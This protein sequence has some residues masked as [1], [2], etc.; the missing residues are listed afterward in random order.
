MKW[1]D[2]IGYNYR[3]TDLQAALGVAQMEKV[4]EIIRK[5]QRAAAQYNALLKESEEIETPFV[6]QGY[7]HAYQSYV[8]WYKK[9]PISPENEK[10]IDGHEIDRANKERNRLMMALEESGIAVRQGTHAVHTLGYY[11]EKY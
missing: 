3:M 4:D 9:P 7:E 6:P 1:H 8:C 11:K 2:E 5:R 10:N